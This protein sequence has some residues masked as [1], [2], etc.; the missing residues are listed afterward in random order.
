MQNCHLKVLLLQDSR[1]WRI[2][3]PFLGHRRKSQKEALSVPWKE[4]TQ[5]SCG[6]RKYCCPK[7]V[8]AS[9]HCEGVASVS[10]T[11]VVHRAKVICNQD[12]L[13]ATLEFAQRTFR[14]DTQILQDLNPPETVTPGTER[15]SLTDLWTFVISCTVLVVCYQNTSEPGAS[16]WVKYTVYFSLEMAMDSGHVQHF[17]WV[18]Y[19]LC[20]PDR[21]AFIIRTSVTAEQRINLG[22]YFCYSTPEISQWSWRKY[23]EMAPP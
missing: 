21:T 17:L 23:E 10:T 19:S 4:E 16:C 2:K 12:R 5:C 3:T 20:S 8:V 11:G 15:S 13:H 18:W 9:F 14:H 22:H 7:S 6:Y 1:K